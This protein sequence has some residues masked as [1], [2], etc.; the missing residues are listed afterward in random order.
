MKMKTTLSRNPPTVTTARKQALELRNSEASTVECVKF[1]QILKGGF[2]VLD[3]LGFSGGNYIWIN[4]FETVP[5]I[6][7]TQH[8]DTY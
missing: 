4:A 2:L 3:S 1:E 5:L 6:V 7:R 8:Q